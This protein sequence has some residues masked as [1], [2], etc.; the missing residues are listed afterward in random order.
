MRQLLLS[1]SLLGLAGSAFA[2]CPA[3]PSTVLAGRWTFQAGTFTGQFLPVVGSRY[4]RTITTS[5][6]GAYLQ[7]NDWGT[8]SYILN[9]DCLGGTMFFNSASNVFQWDFTIVTDATFGRRI[10]FFSTAIPGANGT[11]QSGTTGGFPLPPNNPGAT[12]PQTLPPG[13]SSSLTPAAV[14]NAWP[15]PTGCPA[16]IGALNNFLSGTYNTITLS[17]VTGGSA[18]GVPVGTNSGASLV[19]SIVIGNPGT[20]TAFLTPRYATPPTTPPSSSPVLPSTSISGDEGMYMVEQDCQRVR[21]AINFDWPR[22]MCYIG[23]PRIATNGVISFVVTG[24]ALLASPPAFTTFLT[25]SGTIA[26]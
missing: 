12:P 19:G 22:P 3:D 9:T 24:Q 8:G 21:F 10:N 16:G 1:I 14:G 4:F 17:N 13:F 25:S 23:Y 7:D 2:Q 5:S 11:N 6:A 20:L 26:R 18:Q 15:A